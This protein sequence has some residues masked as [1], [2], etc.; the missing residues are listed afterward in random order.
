M[1]IGNGWTKTTENGDTYIPIA[2]DEVIENL[3]PQLKKCFLT[4]WHVKQED[5]KNENSPAWTVTLSV[6]K[7][8]TE[9]QANEEEIPF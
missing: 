4:L 1:K 3:Y 6:K 5:R 7:D 8:K 9:K 2:L